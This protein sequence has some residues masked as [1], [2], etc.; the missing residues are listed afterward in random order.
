M[1]QSRQ[2]SLLGLA[3]SR[4]LISPT[5]L[6]QVAMGLPD[7]SGLLEAVL[8]QGLLAA[9]DVELLSGLV[10]AYGGSGAQS[11]PASGPP[12]RLEEPGGAEDPITQAFASH[13]SADRA[14]HPS[15]SSTLGRRVLDV[16]QLTTWKHYRHLEFLGEGG[17]GRIFKAFDPVLKR[18]VALKF[19]A[20]DEP[21]KI[22][23][24]V[25]EAQHQA[26]VDHPNI[27]KVF[28]VG[29]WKG[30][31]YIAM[32]LI[33]GKTLAQARGELSLEE[34]V[35]VMQVVAE[36]IHA[37]HRQGLIH[38]DLKPGNIM[39]AR[40]GGGL[41]P[42]ILDF[43]LA[44][45]LEPTGLTQQGVAV[46]TLGYMA[47]EQAKGIEG[48]VGFPADIYGMGA[49]LYMLLAGDPPFVDSSGLELLRRTVE[50]EPRPMSTLD[51]NL[52]RDLDTIVMKCLE[53]E[54]GRRYPSALAL[55]EDLRRFLAG[56]PLLAIPLDWRD[57]VRKKLRRNRTL[58][59]VVG[60]A[61][62][63]VL[64]LGG[65]GLRAQWRARAQSLLAQRFGMESERLAGAYRWAQLLPLHDMRPNKAELRAWMGRLEAQMKSQGSLAKGPG[66]FALGQACLTLGEPQKALV[67]LEAAWKAGHQDAESAELLGLAHG[68]VLQE[69]LAEVPRL[70]T[71]ALKE[72]RLA[73]LK[74]LHT[75]PALYFLRLSG[76]N[77]SLVQEGHIAFL[78]E[79]Y[80]EALAKAQQA[81]EKD[82]W[83]VEAN[84]L[85]GKVHLAR[86][87]SRIEQGNDAGAAQATTEALAAAGRAEVTARSLQD[88]YALEADARHMELE[89]AVA[90]G[91][92]VEGPA[93][94]YQRALEQAL[95]VDPET[96]DIHLK[97]TRLY[98]LWA[99]AQGDAGQDPE[100]HLELALHHCREAMRFS[101]GQPV[102]TLLLSLTYI[103]QA[104]YRA[105]HGQDPLPILEQAL[106]FAQAAI[107]LR[108][109]DAIFYN[110][111]GMAFLTRGQ[112]LEKHGRKAKPDF[113]AAVAALETANRLGPGLYYS[114][115]NR[116][117]C[118]RHLAMLEAVDGG[119]PVPI[120]E[121][122][123]ACYREAAKL[124]PNRATIHNN[125]GVLCQYKAEM[126]LRRGVDA[127]P[128]LEEA[129][130][131]LKRA[132][133]INGKFASSHAALGDVATLRGLQSRL[134]GGDPLP[135][136]REAIGHFRTA[137][138]INA[139]DADIHQKLGRA[140]LEQARTLVALGRADAGAL[141]KA[142]LAF[143]TSLRIDAKRGETLVDLARV[144]L[145][146]S[147]LAEATAAAAKARAFS[148][149]TTE[150]LLLQAE[151]AVRRAEERS[152]RARE[153]ELNAAQAYLK[154]TE[155][156]E[157]WNPERDILRAMVTLLRGG[158]AG[159]ASRHAAQAEAEF[160]RAFQEDR[161]LALDHGAWLAKAKGQRQP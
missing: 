126:E 108:P 59:L 141:D 7:G 42:F 34:K 67:H 26:K 25:L 48:A 102:A 11:L 66:H 154:V 35:G 43:G 145:L 75:G 137:L 63:A 32:Q 15:Q 9:D 88:A 100:P 27:C 123:Q 130:T 64:V 14:A 6:G 56:E 69:A 142:R 111:L 96:A 113:Q 22:L 39:V 84:L 38:R 128:S 103:A 71:K 95:A 138:A 50:E 1:E 20:R 4:D 149:E 119:N 131:A 157:A 122:A 53:K 81:L 78:E 160:T 120:M 125:L 44:R 30:Q 89:L 65:L 16:Q 107:K 140:W 85:M 152:G 5:A 28:E 155:A 61:T 112:Y 132:L 62:V 68:A 58:S 87:R 49:T 18:E 52:P 161:I 45:G 40:D 158:T 98:R 133:A 55:A 2:A 41:K 104:D 80:D 135:S 147:S 134:G 86:A 8:A 57:A 37:A 159:E 31:S 60:V 97:L 51:L 3:V 124:N 110:N 153:A 129:V 121:Q 74:Q 76:S 117:I 127:R 82:P 33:R 143:E 150:T 115:V 99:D 77:P 10:E 23:R 17:M 47:P 24:F 146:R 46:G 90:R 116:G 151:I 91:L 109:E 114:W 106:S 19:L 70:G 29:E 21:D 72:A 73:E 144:H 83:L 13:P 92:P 93:Q 101:P 36:A 118:L 12:T 139:N 136:F 148:P 105:T 79:R 94:A 156:M 54:P